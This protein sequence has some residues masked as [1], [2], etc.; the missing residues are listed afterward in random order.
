MS[1]HPTV[2]RAVFDVVWSWDPINAKEVFGESFPPWCRSRYD[3]AKPNEYDSLVAVLA[4]DLTYERGANLRALIGKACQGFGFE[5]QPRDWR[6]ADTL[7][8]IAADEEQCD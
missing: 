1:I 6:I 8:S 3:P 4:H 2:H 7:S 5:P